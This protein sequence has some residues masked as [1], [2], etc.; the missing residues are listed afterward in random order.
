MKEEILVISTYPPKGTI[1][2]SKFS[3]VASYTK[4]TLRFMDKEFSFRVL[5][6]K[7]SDEEKRYQEENVEVIRCWQRGAPSLLFSILRQIIMD[8]ERKILFCFEWGMFG[9]NLLSLA[10]MPLFLILL[11]IMGKEIYLVCHGVVLNCAKVAPQLGQKKDSIKTKTFSLGLKFLYLSIVVLSKRVIVFEESLRQDL[12]KSFKNEEKIL[13]IPHGV[14]GPINFLKKTEARKKL[15][16]KKDEFLL[17][18]FGFLAWY[19]GSDW[20]IKTMAHYFK[21]NP[22]AKMRLLM[23]GGESKV[24]KSDPVY[25]KYL[26]RLYKIEQASGGKILITGFVPEKKIGLYF[27]ASDLVVLPY[28]VVVSASGPLSFVF[29]YRKPFLLSKNLSSYFKANDFKSALVETGVKEEEITFS[30]NSEVFA[31][32][33]KKIATAN[34]FSSLAKLSSVMA[35]KR[36]FRT[37]ANKYEFVIRTAGQKTG[38]EFIPRVSSEPA[39]G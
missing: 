18:C 20:I 34:K 28:R 29:S 33:I 2:G 16:F 6:D 11:R 27:T 22:N 35:Q 31:Q 1:Y 8:G 9:R 37:L 25:R 4:N 10:L 3:A 26:D 15:N 13:T 19:K 23:V 39:V 30:L 17:L 21:K 38:L 24:H 7:L 36:D 32:K 5:A 12:I 14:D